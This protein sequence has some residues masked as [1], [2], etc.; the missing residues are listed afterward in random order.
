[1][2]FLQNWVAYV[3]AIIL[4]AK[5]I[6]YGFLVGVDF[7]QDKIMFSPILILEYE[8][9]HLP[10]F[11]A[12][13]I[14]STIF[15]SDHQPELRA[16]YEIGHIHN[17]AHHGLDYMMLWYDKQK[18]YDPAWYYNDW[19]IPKIN[20]AWSLRHAMIEIKITPP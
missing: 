5:W 2:I 17:L 11:G 20:H 12:F 3:L 18:D 7:Q 4:N 15:T 14:G 9:K 8:Q 10:W 19:Q 13:T 16:K 1:M 6:G